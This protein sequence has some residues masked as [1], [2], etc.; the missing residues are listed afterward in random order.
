[1]T[2]FVSQM[3]HDGII[4]VDVLGK[5]SKDSALQMI[6]GKLVY[7]DKLDARF[8]EYLNNVDK[9]THLQSTSWKEARASYLSLKEQLAL[10]PVD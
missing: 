3:I 6:D 10:E 5:P 2:M 4:K 7:N 1:M 8:S 9:P